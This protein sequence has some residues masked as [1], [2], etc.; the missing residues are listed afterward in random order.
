MRP[1]VDEI[2]LSVDARGDLD[3]LAACADLADRRF[4]HE[5]ERN[6]NWLAAWIQ[7]QCD[8]DWILRL[9]DD[10]VPSAALL[11]ALPE[12]LA[13]RYPTVYRIPRRWLVAPDRYVAGFP[14][15]LETLAR[16]LRNHQ[17]LWHMDGGVHR[18]GGWEGESRFLEEPMYH[19]D[20]VLQ[21]PAARRAKAEEYGRHGPGVVIEGVDV[22][23]FYTPEDWDG[24]ETRPVPDADRAAIAHLLDP[25][26]PPAPQTAGASV[27]RAGPEQIGRWNRHPVRF[28]G[29]RYAGAIRIVSRRGQLPTASRRLFEIEVENGGS[30]PWWRNLQPHTPPVSVCWRWQDESGGAVGPPGSSGLPMTLFPGQRARAWIDPT[31]PAGEG[32]HTLTVELA[33]RGTR[34]FGVPATATVALADHEGPVTADTV[35]AGS[36]RERALMA[37]ER[38]F[39]SR[40]RAYQAFRRTRRY[41]IAAALAWPLDTVRALVGRRSAS[42][43]RDR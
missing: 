17:G 39:E 20:T 19:L 5:L 36:A 38:A 28:N 35:D 7:H 6:P 3:T 15:E 4:V 34:A 10:E 33:Y 27:E 21:P 37:R 43:L 40:E 2:V 42:S 9:D 12:L 24:L 1:H 23:R 22:N 14:W 18:E 16:L 13:D 31:T 8:C 11:D 25:P 26:A 30:E 41:R 32:P 29:E